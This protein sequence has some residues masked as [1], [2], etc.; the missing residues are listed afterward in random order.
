VE[1]FQKHKTKDLGAFTLPDNPV[2]DLRSPHQPKSLNELMTMTENIS[3]DP[4]LIQ[5]L[6][7]PS[8]S[9][10][11]V[12]AILHG[13]YFSD[14]EIAQLKDT[15]G[16][17]VVSYNYQEKLVKDIKE[18]FRMDHAPVGSQSTQFVFSTL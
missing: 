3:M 15:L 9:D 7:D 10:N 16:T 11:L 14:R 12:N 13:G 1:Y 8:F 2:K 6:E 4:S 17:L 5:L 18:A